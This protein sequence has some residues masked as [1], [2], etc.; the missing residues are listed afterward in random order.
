MQTYLLRVEVNLESSSSIL[1]DKHSCMQNTLKILQCNTFVVI[2]AICHDALR[3][4]VYF[5]VLLS[6]HDIKQKSMFAIWYVNGSSHTV[7][8]SEFL[9]RKKLG[10]SYS[11]IFQLTI[12]VSKL[13]FRDL[14]LKI[15][16]E[17]LIY[18]SKNIRYKAWNPR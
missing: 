18:K 3:T 8:K 6:S 5:L 15:D 4:F 7:D 1:N 13:H 14:K 12:L 2:F 17:Y 11:K 9:F 16:S 10:S